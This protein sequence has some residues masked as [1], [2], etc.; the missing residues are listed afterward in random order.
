MLLQ[1]ARVAIYLMIYNIDIITYVCNDLIRD[2]AI[3]ICEYDFA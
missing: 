1:L 3:F 2:I